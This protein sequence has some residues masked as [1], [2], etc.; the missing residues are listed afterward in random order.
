[1]NW[2]KLS[3]YAP[4]ALR[5]VFGVIFLIH[6][7]MKFTNLSMTT[8]FF[9][10]VNIPLPSFMAFAIATLEVIGGIGL[11]LGVGTRLFA[12][13]LTFEMLFAILLARISAGFVGGY[14]FELALLAGL[15]TLFLGGPGNPALLH[16]TI[17]INDTSP[18]R[19]RTEPLA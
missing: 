16:G 19:A 4:L 18:G 11:I 12:L 17:D 1:M 9:T 2:Q 3:P 7:I 6:G 14:E 10:S 8:Q 13:L 5:L 15:L